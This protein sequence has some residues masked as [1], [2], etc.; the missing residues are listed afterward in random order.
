MKSSE[1]V[2]KVVQYENKGMNWV[3]FAQLKGIR[4][5]VSPRAHAFDRNGTFV[6]SE[7]QLAVYLC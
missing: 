4:F 7:S 5:F 1:N 6:I 2:M 3:T